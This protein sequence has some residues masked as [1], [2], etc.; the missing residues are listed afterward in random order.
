MMIAIARAMK[1][2]IAAFAAAIR[3]MKQEIAAFAA[4]IEV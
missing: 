3:A 2:E 1:Q 4:A